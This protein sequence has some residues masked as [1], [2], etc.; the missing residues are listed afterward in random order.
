MRRKDRDADIR[1]ED[2]FTEQDGELIKQFSQ[3]YSV[4]SVI[5]KLKSSS[6]RIASCHLQ[7]IQMDLEIFTLS[8]I[9]Q[10][11]KVLLKPPWTAYL[12]EPT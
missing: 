2:G 12:A 8:E 11:E 7:A 1:V 3:V 9:G 5:Y 6:K 10:T 4:L